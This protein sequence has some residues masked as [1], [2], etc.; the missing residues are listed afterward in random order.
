MLRAI[1]TVAAVLWM[2]FVA[3]E[4]YQSWPTI[5]LDMGGGGAQLQAAYNRAV[6]DHAMRAAVIALVPAVLLLI[7]GWLIGRRRRAIA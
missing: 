5:P 6:T 7:V 3:F 4:A 2:G 1:L